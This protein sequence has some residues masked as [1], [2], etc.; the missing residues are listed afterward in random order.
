MWRRTPRILPLLL[1]AVAFSLVGLEPQPALAQT[2]YVPYYGKNRPRYDNFKWHIYKTDHFEIYYYPELQKHLERAASYAESAYQHISAELK[3]D[4]QQKVPLI[5]FKTASEFQENNIIGGE[6]PEGVL[7]FAE[8]ERNRMV[9]PIDLPS[10]QLYDLITHELTHVFEF[11]IIPRG[12]GLLNNLPLWMD[13]GLADYMT[14]NWNPL[15]LMSVRDVAISDSVPKMS[16]LESQPLSGRTPYTLGHATFEFI[17]SKWGK[18]GMRAFLFSLRKNVIGGGDSAYQEALKISPDEFDEQFDRYLK[19][20]FKPFRD[21]E[22]PSDYGRSIAPNPRRTRFPVTISVDA[23]PQGDLLAA[24]VGNRH[25]QELDIAIISAK[26][27]QVVQNLTKGLDHSRGFEYIATPGGMRGNLVPWIAYAPD[28]DTIAYFVRT[29]KNRTLIIQNVVNARTRLKIPLNTVDGPESPAYS[30]DGKTIAFSAMQGAVGDIFIVDLATKNITNVTND[31]YADYAPAFSPDG[32][33]IVYSARISGNDKLFQVDLATSTK[34]QITFGTHDDEGPKFID[35]H[36]IVFTSMATDPKV[37]LDPA[38]ARNG[39]IPNVWTLDL[40]TNVLKQL[41]DVVTGNVSPVVLKQTSGTKIA[42]ITNYKDEYGVHVIAGD[43]AIATVDSADF[44]SPGPIFDFVPQVS[45]TLLPDNIHKK[46]VFEKMTLAGRPPVNL[47]VTSGGYFYGNTEITFTDVL[48]DKTINFFA[49]SYNQFRTT[50]LTYVNSER[51]LQYALQ[52][53]SQDSFYYGANEAIFYDPSL[54]PYVVDSRDLVQAVTSQRGFLA[55]GIYPFNRYARAEL[56]S[57]Y[58]RMS[59]SYNDPNLQLLSEQYQMQQ[60]GSLLFRNGNMLPLRAAF[61]KETTVFREYGPLAGST[62]SFGYETSPA[63]SNNWLS[64][65]TIDGDVRHYTRLGAN[66]VL[67]LRLKGMKSWGRNPDYFR[68]GG[69]SE[70]RGYDYLSFNGQKGFFANAELRFP[71]IEAMLTPIGVV[72]GLRGV[73]F[74]NMGG[75]GFDA[76]G[77]YPGFKFWTRQSEVLTPIINYQIVDQFGGYTPVFGPP[78]QIDGFRLVDG[79]ASYGFGLESFLLG[80][81][82]HFDW[83][84]RTLFNREWENV[85]FA[86]DGALRGMSGSDYLRQVKFSFWIGYDF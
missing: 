3:H 30:P 54:A 37:P 10:D 55:Y 13:E 68:F 86:Y 15:D 36:T 33:T 23:A 61:V 9:L 74:F 49:Q 32:K 47:G 60:Y 25:D 48:G 29:E 14:G 22:R 64:R 7:A 24:V 2:A 5:L 73:F 1:G 40:N 20:R 43:K 56:S 16:E 11:D 12:L 83:S 8:P 17:E 77:D 85:M 41:T 80:F 79:R 4:L 27:G 66:G 65:Q 31:Q 46:G 44:G 51:R 71:L 28:G 6:T 82:M 19:E 52:G 35:D 34:K 81:P 67:A 57:G 63:I 39:N 69:N 38:V 78:I 84:W 42:F 18:D 50:A 58:I 76:M 72:G 21:K 75:T 26:D 45:H 62:M 59:E 70:M 53:F